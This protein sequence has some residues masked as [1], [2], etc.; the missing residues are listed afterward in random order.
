SR[1][2]PWA[3]LVAVFLVL[4]AAVAG[5]GL[6]AVQMQ[7]A[8][9]AMARDTARAAAA[10]AARAE[11]GTERAEAEGAREERERAG[12]SKEGAVAQAEVE[13][14][15]TAFAPGETIPAR[16]TGDREDVS[17][18]LSWS[19][20]PAGTKELALIMDDP[21]APSAEPWVHWVMYKIPAGT[22]GLPEGVAPQ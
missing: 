17:P 12:S 19:G 20:A 10:Q 14:R 22:A 8:A 4:G 7:R 15:S 11:A 5:L 1:M 6:W 13:V 9:E 18:A 2:K 16:F 21:D 3:W